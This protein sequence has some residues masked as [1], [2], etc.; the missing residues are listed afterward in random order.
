M[1][2]PKAGETEKE[3]LNRCIPVVLD[4]G[5]AKDQKQAVAICKQMWR[6]KDKKERAMAEFE[7]RT[8]PID[9]LE[10]RESE[11]EA[12]QLSGRAVPFNEWSTGTLRTPWGEE[13][14]ERFEGPPKDPTDVTLNV[15]H[16]RHL[17]IARTPKTLEVESD[18][19]GVHFNSSP[20]DTQA[21]RDAVT[22]VRSDVIRNNSFEFRVE[23]G[24][25][26]WD[27]SVKPIRRTI[28]SG[29]WSLGAITLTSAPAYSQTHV[30]ARA[31]E[32]SREAE[33]V[34]LA[35]SRAEARE[36]ALR[37]AEAELDL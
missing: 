30:N 8:I 21:S 36:R 33:G 1:P 4:E 27:E 3:W 18:G 29:G 11:G 7:K 32:E 10:L 14:V 2:T 15:E 13:F 28:K 17:T 16:Q 19:E 6:D 23:A 34:A 26:S 9:S 12:P 20:P 37:L 24:G 22:L 5:T 35:K 25:E 31:L